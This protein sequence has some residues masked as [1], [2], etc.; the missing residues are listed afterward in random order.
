[1]TIGHDGWRL[2]AAIDHAD[3]RPWLREVP[4]VALLRRGW[5]QN[6]W[7]AGPQLH[8]READNIPPAAQ[9]ISSPYDAEA[10]YARTHTTQWVGDTVHLPETCDDALPHLLTNVQSTIGPTADGATTPK[11]HATLEQRNLLPGTPIVDTGFLDAE[12]LV[13][14]PEHYGVDLL[15][16]TRL[17]DH[18]QAR[19]GHGY[20]AQHVQVDWGQQHATCPAGKPSISWTPALDNRGNAVIKGKFSRR[21]CRRCDH[22]AQCVRAKKRYPRRTLTV[23]PQP[24]YQAL[25]AARQR[26]ATEAFQAEYACRAGID[27]TGDPPCGLSPCHNTSMTFSAR[28]VLAVDASAIASDTIPLRMAASNVCSRPLDLRRHTIERRR[29]GANLLGG[30]RSFAEPHDEGAL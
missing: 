21:D 19:A 28:S 13:E 30:Q 18:W 2:L 3:A 29:D 22:V 10:P 17:D 9:C 14:S 8:W 6:Y 20:E 1:M 11:I 7:W 24:Q 16:P 26:E 25:Q 27:K 5:I 4:A 12:L 23:R 15:G